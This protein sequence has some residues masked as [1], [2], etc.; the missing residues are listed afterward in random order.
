M[1]PGTDPEA[2]PILSVLSQSVRIYMG[3]LS[4][5]MYI[6][7][8][9]IVCLGFVV[10]RWL[11]EVVRGLL[12]LL[13]MPG[14]PL[15]P[16]GDHVSSWL[17]LRRHNLQAG[18]VTPTIS[19]VRFQIRN[20]HLECARQRQRHDARKVNKPADNPIGTDRCAHSHHIGRAELSLPGHTQLRIYAAVS[21]VGKIKG[22]ARFV[23]S[24]VAAH[25]CTRPG[26]AAAAASMGGRS[27]PPGRR[28]VGLW[29]SAPPAKSIATHC[30]CVSDRNPLSITLASERWK[31]KKTRAHTHTHRERESERARGTRDKRE[32]A[33]RKRT[34]AHQLFHLALL[35][36]YIVPR[37]L[38]HARARGQP[39][40]RDVSSSVHR[41]RLDAPRI[42]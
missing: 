17:G 25:N 21:C 29:L 11:A 1:R 13:C 39:P 19:S 6:S 35:G 8:N 34:R 7:R 31:A 36:I 33:S 4:Y 26:Q 12:A 2:N 15:N 16:G 30:T 14:L 5:F 42:C 18:T 10:E 38:S 37:A 27:R 9:I 20:S 41:S 3:N 32:R 22:C 23:S 40:E 24:A 28:P